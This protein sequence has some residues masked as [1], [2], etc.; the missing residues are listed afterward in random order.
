MKLLSGFYQGFLGSDLNI[1]I[2]QKT[3]DYLLSVLKILNTI[4]FGQPIERKMMECETR[5]S[6][7]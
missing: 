4:S 5:N 2:L 6:I 1:I 7:R 3:D